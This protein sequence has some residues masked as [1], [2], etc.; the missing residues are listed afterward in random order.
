[1]SL[2]S[3]Q[4]VMTLNGPRKPGVSLMGIF[5]PAIEHPVMLVLGLAGG[6]WLATRHKR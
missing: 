1:M 4:Y 2:G 6:I 3:L 5:D